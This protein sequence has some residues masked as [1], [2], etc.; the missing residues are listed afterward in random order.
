VEI[1]SAD[2][3]L[4]S[5]EVRVENL[6]AKAASTSWTGWLEMP[7]GCGTPDACQ[8]QFNLNASQ[9]ALH[10]LI[11]WVSPR[12]KERPWYRVLEPSSQTGPSFL[13]S[14]RASGRVSADRFQVQG[15][16]ATHVSAN[17]S[18]GSATLWVTEL[19]ADFLDGKHRGEWLADFSGKPALCAGSA[20]LTGISLGNLA[21]AMKDSWITGVADAKYEVKGACSGEFWSTADGTLEFDMK[22]GKLPHVMLKEDAEPLEITHLAGQARLHAGKIEMKDALL[23]SPDGQ[24]QLS[25][26]ASLQREL[27]FKLAKL[28]NGASALGYT[29]TGTL[30]EP[31]VV[32]SSALDTQARL[33]PEPTK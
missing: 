31:R 27:D 6:K 29:I 17:V 11:E 3:R 24:F 2:L 26:T 7:R 9:T 14:L 5:S 28:P 13:A 23:N 8:V 25:G 15:L 1:G 4:S 33:K 18:L 19:N 22:D 20:A 16:T 10:D 21:D 32:R 30:E 12:P